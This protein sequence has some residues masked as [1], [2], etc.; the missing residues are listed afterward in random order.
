M[1]TLELVELASHINRLERIQLF[2][3]AVIGA[4]LLNVNLFITCALIIGV[5]VML[6]ILVASFPADGPGAKQTY[7]SDDASDAECKSLVSDPSSGPSYGR[8]SIVNFRTIVGSML[9]CGH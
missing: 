6:V 5:N 1:T 9:A 3:I 4:S 8:A 7:D 2:L